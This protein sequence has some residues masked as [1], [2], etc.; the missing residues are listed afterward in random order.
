MITAVVFLVVGFFIG[1]I[2]EAEFNWNSPEKMVTTSAATTAAPDAAAAGAPAGATGGGQL[3]P[4][5]PSLEAA[6]R[7]NAL[8]TQAR[9]NPQDPQLPLEL[10]NLYYDQKQYDH[11]ADWYQKALALDPKN[12][13]ARTD[14]GTVYFNLGRPED[15]L[16]AYEES[17]RVD[18]NHEPT[19]FNSI[20]VNLDGTHNLAAARAMY[21]KLHKRNPNYPGLENLKDRVVGAN[22]AAGGSSPT[23]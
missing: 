9:Q 16:K 13:N 2:T 20:I 18:P 1:Y 21:E 12:V 8:E 23:R 17:L 4:G 3:P 5:H 11:A 14:L 19:M 10:A 15:A 22:S 7:I 6:T